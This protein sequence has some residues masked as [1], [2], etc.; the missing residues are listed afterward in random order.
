MKLVPLPTET[1]SHTNA[2]PA[3]H[4]LLGGRLAAICQDIRA[5]MA[6]SPLAQPAVEL[7]AASKTQP[8]AVLREALG[9]GLRAY[10]EN[11]VQEAEA[12]WP[13]LRA[14]FP[15]LCLHLIGPL[16]SNKARQAL[17]LFDVIQTIDRPKL[18]E[19]LAPLMAGAGVRTRAMYIQVNIGEE[20][21]KAG[22]AIADTAALVQQAMAAG[23]PIVGLMCVP[24]A[25]LPAAPF[26]ARLRAL[27][28]ECGLAQ[29]SMGMS[30]DYAVAVRMGA[31]CVRVGQ[32]LF[33]PRPA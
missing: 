32:A 8:E 28:Q 14:E 24:P 15:D 6:H 12:K 18:V 11:R 19:A 13:P 20:P 22:V 26:F 33:G 4:S 10:G 7:L 27:A 2:G 16:Q 25:D 31:S 21:Q 3:S 30:E 1:A 9:L 17:E 23:L 5:A 29:L